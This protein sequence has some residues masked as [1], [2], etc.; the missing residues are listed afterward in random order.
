MRGAERICW[1]VGLVGLVAAAFFWWRQPV[2]FRF[3]W[4]A[5]VTV[6]SGWPIGSM[7]LLLIHA[8]T[9]GRW[10]IALRPWLLLGI[11]T[12]P[13]LLPALVPLLLGVHELYP[14]TRPAVAANLANGFYLNLPFFLGRIAGYLI[15]WFGIAALILRGVSLTRLAPPAL[16]LLALATSFAAID[17]TMSLDP[18]FKSSAYGM[19]AGTGMVLTALSIAILLGGVAA[20]RAIVEDLGKLLLALVVLWTYLD[21]MQLLI[22][23]E[24][25]LASEAPWYVRRMHGSWGAVMAIVAIGH[26]LLPFFLLIVPRVRRSRDGVVAIAALL[27]AMTILR[28]WWI[29]L[30]A[31][32]RGI[33]WV[34]LACLVGIGGTAAAVALRAGDR[35]GLY[36]E[37]RHHA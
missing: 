29:V 4:L 8:L 16:I 2:A 14:W 34:D 12:L 18:Q 36:G 32:P 21:F 19:I 10:G 5:I 22:V 20:D 17:L 24:S 1:I 31:M 37:V 28:G 3:A 33:G 9:G 7:A 35:L 15:V 23:W 26:F 11:A 13:L 30:P 25:N 27:V 6:W